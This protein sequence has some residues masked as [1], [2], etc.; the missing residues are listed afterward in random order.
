MD[1]KSDQRPVCSECETTM[2]CSEN[3]VQV[4]CGDGYVKCGDEY[5]CPECQTRVIIGFGSMWH[6]MNNSNSC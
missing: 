3:D 2:L 1:L 5:A 6:P 4:N